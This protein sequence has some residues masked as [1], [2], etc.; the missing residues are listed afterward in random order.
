MNLVIWLESLFRHV[1]YSVYYYSLLVLFTLDLVFFLPMASTF[2]DDQGPRN[3]RLQARVICLFLIWALSLTLAASSEN[4]PRL[5]GLIGLFF[6]F[7]FF[8]ISRRWKTVRRGFGAPGFMSHWAIRFLL[9]FEIARCFDPSQRLLRTLIEVYQIDFAVIMICAGTY[10]A[11]SG[12]LNNDGMEYGRVN[13]SWGYHWRFFGKKSPHGFYPYLMNCVAAIVELVAGV[14]MLI[15]NSTT[16]LLGAIAI[17]LSFYYVANFI[18]LGRLAILMVVLPLLYWPTVHN[19]LLEVRAV[20]WAPLPFEMPL[21]L[22]STVVSGLVL[23]CWMYVGI[24]PLVKFNQYYNML[25]GRVLPRWLHVPLTAFA[26]FVPI[27]IWR[28]FTADLVNFYVRIVVEG[29]RIPNGELALVDENLYSARGCRRF[30][31]KLRYLHVTESIA[32]T[33]LFTT[34]KYF[35]SNRKMF[36]DKMCVYSNVFLRTIDPL[37]EK[38]V[39]RIRY[40]YISIQKA[41]ESFLYQHVGNF[42]F[43]RATQLIREEKVDSDFDFSARTEHS[44]IRETT[45]RGSYEAKPSPAEAVH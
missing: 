16:R 2:F 37:I 43:D 7:R 5:L 30:L 24:L 22:P 44:P 17:S 12:Y 31:F 40:E 19:N 29:K 41:K 28:V 39:E 38:D 18:R 26:N 45:G 21:E 34:L 6:L 20:S 25:S 11:L 14:F 8:F 32:L 4:A 27:I 13:P 33:S 3:N 42:Y 15:P 1:D 36:D 23:L 35:K 10:K 9:F